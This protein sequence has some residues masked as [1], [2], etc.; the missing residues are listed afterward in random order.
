VKKLFENERVESIPYLVGF[1]R[2]E[3]SRGKVFLEERF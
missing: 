2:F 1:G 3:S